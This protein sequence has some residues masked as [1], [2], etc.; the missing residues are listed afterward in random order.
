MSAVENRT[1]KE[2][3]GMLRGGLCHS[4]LDN[5]VEVIFEPRSGGGKKVSQVTTC[6]TSILSIYVERTVRMKS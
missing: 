6:V 1:G 4:K 3:A 2:E 5:I